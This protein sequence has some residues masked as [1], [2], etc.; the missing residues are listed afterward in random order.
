VDHLLEAMHRLPQA[1]AL[2]ID[3]GIVHQQLVLAVGEARQDR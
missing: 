3:G 1:G 2:R